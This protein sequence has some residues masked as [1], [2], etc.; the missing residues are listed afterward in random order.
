MKTK[1]KKAEKPPQL[2]QIPAQISTDL[3]QVINAIIRSNT[4]EQLEKAFCKIL[5][6]TARFG[7]SQVLIRAYC[8]R[9]KLII[10]IWL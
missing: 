9:K 1:T 10:N 4:R 5:D 2:P 6:Y 3:M 8:T 7:L